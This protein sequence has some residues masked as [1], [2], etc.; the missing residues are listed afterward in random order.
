MDKSV[1]S[2]VHPNNTYP[3]VDGELDPEQK[4]R[5]AAREDSERARNRGTTPT[6]QGVNVNDIDNTPSQENPTG[7]TSPEEV[8][9]GVREQVAAPTAPTESSPTPDQQAQPVQE[10]S[11]EGQSNNDSATPDNQ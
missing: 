11:A 7:A 6:A 10:Q 1:V 8:V 3:L 9:Q 5:Q 2:G 4:R